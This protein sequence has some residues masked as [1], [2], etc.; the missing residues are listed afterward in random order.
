MKTDILQGLALAATALA[1]LA[2]AALAE[3]AQPIASASIEAVPAPFDIL[4]TQVELSGDRAI[5]RSRLRDA[6]GSATPE[7]TGTFPGAGVYAYV[8]PT[9]L[10]SADAGF[11]ANQGILALA[12]TF[13]PDFDDAAGGG[14][15]RDHWHAHWVVLG[16]DDTCK[17]GLRVID[18]PE[19]ESPRLPATWPGVP[20]LIDSPD[21]PTLLSEDEVEVHV[22]GDALAALPQAAF[23]GVTAGLRVNADLH[24]PLL[25]VEEVFK[26]A[27][28]DLSLPGRVG[29]AE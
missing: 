27:S 28:G 11:A 3:D 13:H 19:G 14:A 25:C 16:K 9:S 17:G 15:N 8:W 29:A 1:C 20:L 4:E 26:V 21:F 22:T 7:A 5:F 18:I 6:A 12:A 24:A 23:D 2:Q 10:N